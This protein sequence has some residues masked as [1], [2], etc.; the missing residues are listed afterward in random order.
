MG[1]IVTKQT[2]HM[3]TLVMKEVSKEVAKPM[4]IEN[5]Y[6]H[7]WGSQFGLINVGVFRDDVLL[8]VAVFGWMKNAN[9]YKSIANIEKNEIIELNRLWISDELGKNAETILLG[10]CWK[11]LR[12][13]YPHIKLV[14]SFADGRLGC[15]TI[16]K[17]ANFRYY[18]YHTSLFMEH[19]VTGEIKQDTLFNNG[20][21]IQ[22]VMDTNADWLDGLYRSF[23]VK[24]YRYIY[25]LDKKVEIYKK[26][27][28]YPQYDKGMID[29][30]YSPSNNLIARL[31]TLYSV[32]GDTKHADKVMNLLK[33]RL[34]GNNNEVSRLILEQQDDKNVVK[35]LEKKGLGRFA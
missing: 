28:P 12:A 20:N 13:D 25:V 18:G 32:T 26:E 1:L 11:I 35:Y 33:E 23:K 17:A 34:N 14:Q 16:Y 27:K 24:T 8:G 7:K 21:S 4:I 2:K 5:H 15:G 9:S 19:L 31:V 6:S 29:A 22:T 3:G 10:A 30:V